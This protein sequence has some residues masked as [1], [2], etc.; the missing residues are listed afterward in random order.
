MVR[1]SFSDLV[2]IIS[3]GRVGQPTCNADTGCLPSLACRAGGQSPESEGKGRSELVAVALMALTATGCAVSSSALARPD[4]GGSQV[5]YRISEDRPLTFA[6]VTSPI[7]SHGTPRPAT[8]WQIATWRRLYPVIVCPSSNGLCQHESRRASFGG[9]HSE[10][11]WYPGLRR[12]PGWDGHEQIHRRVA[13][14]WAD[15]PIA[16][17]LQRPLGLARPL[18]STMSSAGYVA[19]AR[20]YFWSPS[21]R[22]SS[23]IG[24][25]LWSLPLPTSCRRCALHGSLPRTAS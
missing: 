17:P 6:L 7:C 22:C 5:I 9:R 20:R 2:Q 15:V 1:T 13:L 16:L 19:G 23:P 24:A 21:T 8:A 11:S 4:K 10:G 3:A 18:N 14:R 25:V 12:L